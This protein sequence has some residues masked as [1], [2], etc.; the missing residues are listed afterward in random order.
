MSLDQ[1]IKNVNNAKITQGEQG[2]PHRIG[3]VDYKSTLN[4]RELSQNLEPK[5]IRQIVI[6]FPNGLETYKSI[7]EFVESNRFNVKDVYFYDRPSSNELLKT[8]EEL[9][10]QIAEMKAAQTNQQ[11]QQQKSG[12]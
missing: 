9:T 1:F 8:I 2:R 3:C 5:M 10:K 7:G 12:W 11:Q 6:E 4:L